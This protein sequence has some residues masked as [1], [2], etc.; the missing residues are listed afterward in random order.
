MTS[1][2]LHVEYLDLVIS[3]LVL[4]QSQFPFLL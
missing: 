4:I 3:N 1:E 2:F